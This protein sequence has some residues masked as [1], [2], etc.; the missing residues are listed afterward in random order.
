MDNATGGDR[1]FV[2]GRGRTVAPRSTATEADPPSPVS[3][4]GHSKLAGELA[5]VARA[6]ELPISI[7]RPPI[8]L[9]EGDATCCPLFKM[10][11]RTGVHLVAGGPDVQ[12]STIHVAD[13]VEALIRAAE[14][15]QRLPRD[16][17]QGTI[18][19]LSPFAE[20]AEQKGTVPLS[21]ASD[22]RGS[23]L[24]PASRLRHI[25]NLAC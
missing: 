4:Y 24:S 25:A 5:A 21:T 7:V 19:G 14:L 3:N 11:A 20:S 18:R 1:R 16:E 10:I 13:L 9:G 2:T 8:V 22:S 23:I 17:G 15:G 12:L 6:G